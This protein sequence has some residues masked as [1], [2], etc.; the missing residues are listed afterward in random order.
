MNKKLYNKANETNAQNVRNI[1]SNIF[2]EMQYN[3]PFVQEIFYKT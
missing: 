1:Y 3:V 2:D